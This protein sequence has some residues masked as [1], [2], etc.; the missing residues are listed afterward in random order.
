ML[1]PGQCH[2]GGVKATFDTAKEPKD[3]GARQ[4]QCSFCRMHGAVNTSDAEGEIV[5]EAAES[6]LIRYRFGHRTADFLICARCGVYVG[7]AIGEGPDVRATLNVAGLAM[8]EFLA[9]DALPVEYGSETAEQRVKR[10]MLLWTPARFS[11]EALAKS[12]FGPHA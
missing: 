6:D 12:Y 10:R 8:P 11:D 9:V 1:Y 2:C 4:C 3:L 7:A 5:F